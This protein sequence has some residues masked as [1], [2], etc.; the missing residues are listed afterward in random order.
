[1]R[2]GLEAGKDTLDLAVE[3]GVRGVPISAQALVEQG[4]E[5]TLAPLRARGLEVCQIG[6]FGYNPLSSD[7]ERQAAQSAL[8]Q[9][10]LPL[11]P[12]TGCTYITI[13]GGNRHPSGFGAGDAYNYT[14]DALDEVAGA[15]APLL[16]LAERHGCALTI[17]AY[18][19]TAIYS[20]DRFLALQARTGSDALRCNKE[21]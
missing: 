4:V 14:D 11:A 5:A 20:A 12:E 10:V 1:M 21:T 19:K 3:L 13:C 9:A 8:L 18:L 2:L 17:E 16:A 7:T 6:A 15:L